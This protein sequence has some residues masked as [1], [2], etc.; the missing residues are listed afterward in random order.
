M[1]VEFGNVAHLNTEETGWIIGFS[2][3]TKTESDS[4]NLRHVP[5]NSN[6]SNVCVKWSHHLVGNDGL[7]NKPISTGRT[8][9]ILVSETGGFRIS[10]SHSPNFN[11]VEDKDNLLEKHGDFVMWGDGIYHKAMTEKDSTILTIRWA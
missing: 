2:D 10:F 8:I 9:S 4:A 5:L 6:L 3:W 7:Q 11:D 1:D